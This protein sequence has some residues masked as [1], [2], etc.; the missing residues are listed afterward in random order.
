MKI[1]IAK[2]KK[3]RKAEECFLKKREPRKKMHHES[4]RGKSARVNFQNKMPIPR[5]WT[6]IR[7]SALPGK[8]AII[9]IA[10]IAKDTL[11]YLEV[12]TQYF[13]SQKGSIF[14]GVIHANSEVSATNHENSTL[15]L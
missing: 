6:V 14:R 5:E 15:F 13:A 4:Q 8:P 7:G 12:E 11:N 10:I 2:V 9:T 3:E 1:K